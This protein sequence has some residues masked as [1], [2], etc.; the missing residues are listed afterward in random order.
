MAGVKVSE[1]R[2]NAEIIISVL[3]EL[4]TVNYFF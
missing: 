4:I 3:N 2:V 1:C